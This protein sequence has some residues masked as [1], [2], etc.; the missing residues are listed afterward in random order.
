[1]AEPSQVRAPWRTT[2]RTL[3]QALI[4]LCAALPVIVTASG[5]EQTTAGVGLGLAVAA[6]VTRVMAAPAVNDWIDRYVPWL[7]AGPR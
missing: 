7:S 2:V 4:G 3:F 1:M 5:V 6:G